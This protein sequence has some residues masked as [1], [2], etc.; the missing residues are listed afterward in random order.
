MKKLFILVF[1]LMLVSFA[2]S[3]SVSVPKG[4]YSKGEYLDINGFASG[5]VEFVFT[6]SG[7]KN[8]ISLVKQAE[9]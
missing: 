7:N 1:F 5:A 4:D 9:S 3:L 6:S 2:F 8:V